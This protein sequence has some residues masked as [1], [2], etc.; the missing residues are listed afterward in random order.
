MAEASAS[1]VPDAARPAVA[2]QPIDENAS[3]NVASRDDVCRRRKWLR[4]ACARNQSWIA[5][6]APAA[7]MMPATVAAAFRK[8]TA[9]NTMMS[10]ANTIP[11]APITASTLARTA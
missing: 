10:G 4:L 8:D 5:V 2:A 11:T 6:A 7:T 9:A 3:E 1:Q